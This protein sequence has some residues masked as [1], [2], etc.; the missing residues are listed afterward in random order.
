MHIVVLDANVL[1]GIET[2]DLLLTMA[3][4]HLFRPHWSPQ[5]L[6]EV[7][8]N[9]GKRPDLD[10]AAIRRRLDL[11]NTALPSALEEVP[12]ELAA[13]MPV[14]EKDRHVLAL[15]VKL[16]AQTIVTQNLRDFPEELLA[17]YGIEAVSSDGF[18]RSVV[19]DDPS[20]VLAAIDAMAARRVRDPKTRADIISSLS[21]HLPTAMAACEHP[22]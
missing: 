9:L 14:N 15:A 22:P 2:T 17:P 5:I 7:I 21:R 13:Q 4:R 10:D 18:V 11:M 20:A 16:G 6:A 1:Y 3:T 19:E 8:R 12:D